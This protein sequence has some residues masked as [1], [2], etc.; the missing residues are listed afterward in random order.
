MSHAASP[1]TTGLPVPAR[2]AASAPRGGRALLV[3][4][5]LYLVAGVAI[6]TA[7][8]WA[9]Y[10]TPRLVIVAA[11]G[12]ALGAGAVLLVRALRWRGWTIPAVIAVGYLVLVVPVAIPGALTSPVEALRGVRD[13][14][15]GI[16]VGWKQLLTL[17]LPLG[18]YQAVLV[19]YF[20][21][22]VAGTALATSLISRERAGTGAAAG[23]VVALACFGIVFGS[24]SASPGLPMGGVVIPA[25]REVLLG[26]LVVVLSVLWL[27]GRGRLRRAAALRSVQAQSSS[28]RQGAETFALRLRRQIAGILL[29]AIALAAGIALAPV[30]QSIAPRQALRDQVDP[31]LI[32]RQQP[33]PLADYRASFT[34]AGLDA[35]LFTVT[36][37]TG[38]DRLRLATLDGYE[39][40]EFR[41]STGPDGVRFVRLPGGSADGGPEVRITIGDG[42]RGI[43]LPLPDGLAVAP[44][45][46]G[47]RAA[48]L[49]DSFY[50]DAGSG[51]AID[52]APVGQADANTAGA[53][54]HGLVAGDSYAVVAGSREEPAAF[55]SEP[56][57]ESRISAD[58]YPQ[59]AE[60]VER[61]EVARTGAGLAE[62]V[63]RLRERGYLSHSLT[64]SEGST[65]WIA[66]LET[67]GP[68]VFLGSRAGHSAAR[69]EELFADL[70]DQ[71]Q[72]A[73]ADAAP[74][75]LV[76]AVGDDEQFAAAGALLARYL[77]F[78]SRVVVG[79]R[80][81]DDAAASGGAAT[82]GI[83]ACIEV[84]TGAHLTAWVE[85]G[86]PTGGWSTLDVTPQFEVAPVTISDGE[87]LPENP[88]T[89][90]QP[91]VEPLDAPQ[92]QRDDSEAPNTEPPGAP[93]W[94]ESLLPVLRIA[95]TAGLALGLLLLP[96]IV[97]AIAKVVRRR[98]R[99]DDAI[100][101]VS[102][103][104]AWSELVAG[105]VDLGY[106][107]PERVSR[108]SIAEAVGRPRALELATVVD[109]A[110]FS[111]HD[112]EPMASRSAWQLVD[113]ER[114]ELA[115]QTPLRRRFLAAV[116]PAS[117]LRELGAT[118][119]TL[120]RR[121]PFLRKAI[122]P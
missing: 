12:T 112:P 8:A 66:E 121:L 85:V 56:G 89:P 75:D 33:S 86:S 98:S 5:L 117:L 64:D 84:C 36:G 114:R 62:L 1:V 80:L 51:S 107:V 83:P 122:T 22:V 20:V 69:V 32:V 9:V 10:Q 57:T 13:G 26:L 116:A 24:S 45:F 49:A 23:V 81:A 7:S 78:E 39:G 70:N 35:E 65:D 43:W 46:G 110:V 79:V 111:E 40:D 82:V 100:P 21:L 95:G 101:E 47:A 15:V 17:S 108:T 11:V 14:V 96:L 42:Y 31:L 105:Y 28:V 60:W 34:D 76:A 58:D 88:T 77:G 54:A 44:A 104:G 91:A 29:V 73:G 63:D 90:D 55:A 27:V 120:E 94:F 6:A 50:L 106:E 115:A 59:L 93:G 4:G 97:L 67:R 102:M 30:A 48:E 19:P 25:P 52:V 113:D 103:V 18:D 53:D 118:R 71:E 72:R 61:Q 38:V 68:Y 41:V 87:K 92:A 99:R 119:A 3:W 16:V 109:R 74:D 37:A 2:R